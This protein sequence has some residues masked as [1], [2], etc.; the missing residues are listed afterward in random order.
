[1]TMMRIVI[2]LV[3]QGLW[4]QAPQAAPPGTP[5]FDEEVSKQAGIYQSRGAGVPEGY[6]V[7]RSLLSYMVNLSPGF[8]VSLANL[9][10]SDRW[11]DIGAGEGRAVMD[12]CTAKYDA[13]HSQGRERSTGRAQA[14]ALSIEDRRT[15][16]WHQTAASVEAS[17][18]Q[19]LFGRRLREYS[20]QELGRFQLITD[21]LGGFSYTRDLSLFMER[22]LSLLAVNGSFYTLL[23]DVHSASGKNRPYYPDASFLTEIAH[24]DGSELRMCAWLKRIGCVE[25]TCDFK[26][27]WPPPVERYGIRKVCDDVTVP[28]LVPTHFEAGTPPERRFSSTSSSPA[29]LRAGAP[30]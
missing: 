8:K 23:Q 16:R 2:L 6:V 15:V 25:V 17:Q 27:D 29:P 5:L 28:P 22:T 1:M 30:H 7:D 12:Y 20:P 26:P 10:A 9:G 14:V 24:A 21:V 3:L 19:Y 11:L 13:M 4:M 18:M